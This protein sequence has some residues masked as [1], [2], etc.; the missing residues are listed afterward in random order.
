MFSSPGGIYPSAL[1]LKLSAPSTNDTI[2]YTTDGSVPY[3]LSYIYTNEINIITSKVI[4]ACILK[5]GM[6]PGE[7]ITNSYILTGFKNM[8]VV[9]VSMNPADLWDYYTGIYVKGP[10]AQANNPYFGAN[11]WLH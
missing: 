2:Y 4:R 10:N 7:I 11:F 3:R 1:T 6:I 8:P 5:S 9:S